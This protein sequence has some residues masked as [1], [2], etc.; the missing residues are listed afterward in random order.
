MLNPLQ[1]EKPS[2]L[3]YT[4]RIDVVSDS[5]DTDTLLRVAESVSYNPDGEN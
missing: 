2:M 3:P 5:L 4:A 1:P